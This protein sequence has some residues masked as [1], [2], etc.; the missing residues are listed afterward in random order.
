MEKIARTGISLNPYLLKHFD[1]AI[2]K[3]G[4]KKRSE[5]IEDILRDYIHAKKGKEITAII[6]VLYDHR[7]SNY[8]DT[9]TDLEHEYHC[10]I[11]ASTLVYLDHHNCLEVLIVKGPKDRLA[12]IAEKIRKIKG[13]KEAKL[14]L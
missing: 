7:I 14:I 13:V 12:V 10:L 5:A 1:E 2:R 11:L 6:K 3:K 8:G 9:I 4:Y